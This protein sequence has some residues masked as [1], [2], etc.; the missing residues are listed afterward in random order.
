MY[1]VMKTAA[2]RDGSQAELGIVTAPDAEHVGEFSSF[3]MHKPEYW[4]WPVEAPLKGLCGELE[5]RFYV[6]KAGGR[7]VSAIMIHECWG[8]GTIAHVYTLPAWRGKG[9]ASQ[10]MDMAVADFDGRGG[11]VIYL[12]TGYN[13]QPYRIYQRYGFAS[14]KPESGKMVRVKSETTLQEMFAPGDC[15]VA[16]V[17]WR[18]YPLLTPLAAAPGAGLRS[19][20]LM[21]LGAGFE[22]GS[23]E[24]AFLKVYAQALMGKAVMK[25][26]EAPGR[27]VA[28]WATLAPRWCDGAE[29]WLLDF[30]THGNF[31]DKAEALARA[32]PSRPEPVYAYVTSGA[33]AKVPLLKRLGFVEE[34]PAREWAGNEGEVVAWSRYVKA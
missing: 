34:T 20:L 12:G 22:Y 14:I 29:G 16:D 30:H 31:A 1:V 13:T 11:R 23:F 25:V 32:L 7:V 10:I 19:R 26:L 33:E 6:A 28:G 9:L 27:C 15:R 17:A 5:S 8:A 24:A 4:L 18:H 21:D 2:L 3:Y